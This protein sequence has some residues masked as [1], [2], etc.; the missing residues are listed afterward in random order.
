MIPK[1]AALPRASLAAC[2]LATFLSLVAAPD[3]ALAAQEPGYLPPPGGWE[4]I[5]PAQVGMD[6]AGVAEAVRIAVEAE[7]TANR[8][9]A[10]AHLSS[11]GR[12]PLGDAVGPFRTRGPASG[13]IVRGGYV[14]AEWGEPE[15][16]DLTF[17]VAKSFLSATVG[18]AWDRGLLGD[19]HERV[20]DRMGPIQPRNPECVAPREPAGDFPQVAGPFFPFGGDHNGRITWDDL[21]RQTS[22]WQ[23]TLWCK[24]DWADR[25]DQDASTW[26]T[27]ERH[28]PG[29][30]YEYNDTRV[31]LLALAA[32]NLWRRPLPQVLRDHLM[33]PIGASQT[34]RWLGYENSW[35]LLDGNWVQVPSGGSH[36]GGGM[37]ISALDMA[38]FGLLHLRGGAWGDRQILS[39]EWLA[40]ARTPGPANDR[41]GFMNFFLNTGQRALPS[42][43]ESA[44]HHLGAGTNLV[45]VDEEN[46]LVVV[47]RWIRQGAMDELIGQVISAIER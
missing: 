31:N 22:D 38:R 32:T 6:A 30:V 45:Y 24:P 10:L 25:P 19:V 3:S 8:D 41:Y 2:A 12:E 15:R 23:G 18:L 42:A 28:E 47:A 33:E 35:I 1:F 37:F 43:P 39:S 4:R 36:W 34:W 40:M 11:F 46:D 13:V 20:A 21:L 16:V 5:D 29:T 17:S 9:L 26:L 27:R 7:S 14:V 44:Y